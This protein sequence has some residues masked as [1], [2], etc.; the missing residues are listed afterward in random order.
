MAPGH[1]QKLSQHLP[2]N[3]IEGKAIVNRHFPLAEGRERLLEPLADEGFGQQ[4][5][6]LVKP[7]RQ[8]H[9]KPAGQRLARKSKDVADRPQAQGFQSL[10]GGRRQPQRR[11]GQAR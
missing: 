8:D 4:A 1:R 7:L 10:Q 2:A 6:R 9:A 3:E 11:H 5:E